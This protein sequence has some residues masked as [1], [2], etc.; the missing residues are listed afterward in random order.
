MTLKGLNICIITICIITSGY[1]MSVTKLEN[2][3]LELI[4][5]KAST[6]FAQ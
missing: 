4:N 2:K 3:P 6:D 1:V 5:A